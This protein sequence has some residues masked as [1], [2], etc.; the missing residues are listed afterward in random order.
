ML[1]V[2][3]P[4]FQSVLTPAAVGGYVDDKDEEGWVYVK[5]EV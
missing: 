5:D 1:V 2:R 4:V 3:Y